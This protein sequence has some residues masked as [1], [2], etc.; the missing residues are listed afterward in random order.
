MIVGV[1]DLCNIVLG[2]S[3]CGANSVEN[4]VFLQKPDQFQKLDPW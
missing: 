3:S 2:F 4:D 1:V